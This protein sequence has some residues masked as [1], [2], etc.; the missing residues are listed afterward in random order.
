MIATET[1]RSEAEVRAML[2]EL[3]L[4]PIKVKLMDAEEGEGWTLEEADEAEIWYKRFL[5]L[6]F[7]YPDQSIIPTKIIDAFWH[8]HILDTQK[9]AEDCECVFGYFLHHFPYFGL[10]GEEDAANLEKAFQLTLP[11]FEKEFGASPVNAT[12]SECDRSG[13]GGHCCRG[14][15]SER[16]TVASKVRP[17]RIRFTQFASGQC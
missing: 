4:E 10:R 2:E 17:R 1:V 3:D 11:L 15:G 7:K 16:S 13:G 14:C 12:A 9:Y 6:N 8:Q 5:L